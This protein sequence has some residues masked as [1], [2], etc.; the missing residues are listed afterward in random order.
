MATPLRYYSARYYEAT[1]GD[2]MGGRAR[3][4]RDFVRRHGRDRLRCPPDLVGYAWQWL[5][6]AASLGVFPRLATLQVPTLV[7]SGDDDPVMPPAN[8]ILLAH[9]LAN[10]RLLMV[11]GAGH[12]LLYDTDS[13]ALPAIAEFLDSPQLAASLTWRSSERVTSERLASALRAEVL[14][15]HNPVAVLNVLWRYM[16]T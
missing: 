4:D 15:W 16:W 9:H 8:A 2:L 5:A 12:L 3:H 10:A 1:I 14:R 7:V 13:A 6:V 11:L